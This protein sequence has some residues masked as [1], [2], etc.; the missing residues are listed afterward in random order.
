MLTITQASSKLTIAQASL[1]VVITQVSFKLVIA[2]AS[3]M[4]AITQASC[5]LVI[6]SQPS[7]TNSRLPSLKRGDLPKEASHLAQLDLAV[8]PVKNTPSPI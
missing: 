8:N 2:Q 1:K 3:Y 5:T 6:V 7:L 4:L